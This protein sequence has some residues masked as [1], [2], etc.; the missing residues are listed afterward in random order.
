MAPREHLSQS[1]TRGPPS[2]EAGMGWLRTSTAR[3][4]APGPHTTVPDSPRK[5]SAGDRNRSVRSEATSIQFHPRTSHLFAV[6][7]RSPSAPFNRSL[8]GTLRTTDVSRNLYPRT[9]L[10]HCVGWSRTA[11]L[12]HGASMEFSELQSSCEFKRQL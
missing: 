11:E 12:F 6:R 7:L 4:G 8:V 2:P 10:Q 9:S 3:P 5:S 1:S